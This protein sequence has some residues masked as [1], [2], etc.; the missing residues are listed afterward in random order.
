[1]PRDR[2][3]D[4]ALEPCRKNHHEKLRTFLDA[5]FSVPDSLDVAEGASMHRRFARHLNFVRPDFS[6]VEPEQRRAVRRVVSISCDVAVQDAPASMPLRIT[7]LSPFGAWVETASPLAPGAALR[8]TFS[9]PD[10]GQ[11]LLPVTL[12]A[13]VTWGALPGE[14]D[15]MDPGGMGLAFDASDAERARLDAALEA[16]PLASSSDSALSGEEALV[17]TA[18]PA[19]S[20]AARE[21]IAETT[22]AATATHE[23]DADML[24]DLDAWFLETRPATP[25]ETTEVLRLSPVAP[26]APRVAEEP[27]WVRGS[28]VARVSLTLTSY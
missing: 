18:L 11:A 17:W 28:N 5:R 14:L 12:T 15:A 19:P 2:S 6:D 26:G 7:V 10:A 20:C 4:G 1:M 21:A 9:L 16:V 13:R 22:V 25:T 3:L 8:V 27:R 23:P 24:R